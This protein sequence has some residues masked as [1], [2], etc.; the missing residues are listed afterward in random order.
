MNDSVKLVFKYAILSALLSIAFAGQA[1][2]ASTVVVG[3]CK[4]LCRLF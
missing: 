2:N 4:R 3:S 1:A